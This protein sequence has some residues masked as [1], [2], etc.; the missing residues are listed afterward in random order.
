[1]KLSRVAYT[2]LLF[3]D[4]IRVCSHLVVEV[5]AW[6]GGSHGST[7]D[8]LTTMN[9]L[10]NVIDECERAGQRS[11]IANPTCKDCLS[12]FPFDDEHRTRRLWSGNGACLLRG[13]FCLLILPSVAP[14]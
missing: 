10:V 5:C 12:I 2:S 14:N 11:P 7:L 3:G 8:T 13:G 6:H 9:S 1:M 4:E